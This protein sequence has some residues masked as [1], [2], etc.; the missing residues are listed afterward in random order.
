[1]KLDLGSGPAGEPGHLRLDA[2][3]N[4]KP[5]VVATVPPLPFADETFEHIYSSHFIEHLH[6]PDALEA[7]KECHRC[8]KPEGTI[9][10]AVPNGREILR[11]YVEK[12]QRVGPV[13]FG[14]VVRNCDHTDLD[15]LNHL[16]LYSTIQ[17]SHHK[18]LYDEDTIVRLVGLAGFRWFTYGTPRAWWEVVVQAVKSDTSPG[19]HYTELRRKPS[20][21]E[22]RPDRGLRRK[23]RKQHAR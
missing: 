10:I 3:P 23:R 6:R 12:I 18:W 7:L 22:E 21:P 20:V 17:P 1:M 14:E 5:D 19:S 9:I 2:D 4:C 8:L 13:G 16:Y 11:G 15:N